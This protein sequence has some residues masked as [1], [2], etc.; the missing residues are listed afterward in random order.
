MEQTRGS[1]RR[2]SVTKFNDGPESGNYV[3]LASDRIVFVAGRSN[4]EVSSNS[5]LTQQQVANLKERFSK[6][7][8]KA[9]ASPRQVSGTPGVFPE[10]Q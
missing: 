9:I 6:P 7:E 2:Q 3:K 5:G 1:W 10:L 4:S 8:S